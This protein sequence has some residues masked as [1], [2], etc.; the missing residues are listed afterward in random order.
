M[1]LWMLTVIMMFSQAEIVES[2]EATAGEAEAAA[3]AIQRAHQK[4][5]RVVMDI[6][7]GVQKAKIYE[8]GVVVKEYRISGSKN[9]AIVVK[10]NRF[11][12]FTTTGTNIKP[13]EL[14]TSRYSKEHDLELRN[15][16]TF[17]YARGIGAH[18]GD[19]SGYSSGCVRQ[20]AAGAKA[21]FDVIKANSIMKPNGVGIKSTSVT[22]D[23]IDNTPGRYTAECG[24]LRNHMGDIHSARA[25]RVCALAAQEP[26]SK[27]KPKV[28]AADGAVEKPKPVATNDA[29][30]T[31][32]KPKGTSNKKKKSLADKIRSGEAVGLF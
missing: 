27:A 1:S 32:V 28:V 6:T 9:K 16:V 10:G 13:V 22:M 3:A 5:V 23:V 29:G 20:P 19:T 2:E 24:C 18:A 26:Q 4:D 11:C 12:A 14:Q 7:R 25:K 30:T 31:P 21:L 15:F 17:D 8:N